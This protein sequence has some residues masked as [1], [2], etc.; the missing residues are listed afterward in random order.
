MNRTVDGIAAIRETVAETSN[1]VK[2]LGESSQ[3]ISTIVNLISTFTNQT[4]LLA[5]NAAVE[6]AR[7]G[8]E[9]RGF[10][11]VAKEV[12]SLANQSAQATHEIEILVREIQSEINAVVAAMKAGTEQVDVGTKLVNEIRQSLNQITSTSTHIHSLVSTIASS[13][14]AQSKASEA[15]TQ[16]M[17][18]VVQKHSNK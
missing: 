18:N 13:T 7:A 11:F 3:K 12:R 2:Q 4:N 15:V 16:T 9:G 10:G 1:K 17:Y 6:S 8:E 5:L 14:V